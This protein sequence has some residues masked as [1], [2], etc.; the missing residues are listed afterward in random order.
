M[1]SA[2][3]CT[4][5][6]A[7]AE[8]DSLPA[9][10]ARRACQHAFCQLGFTACTCTAGSGVL[11][12]RMQ[13]S[14]WIAAAMQ[15]LACMAALAV[16]DMG[17]TWLHEGMCVPI[18]QFQEVL[19]LGPPVSHHA[20]SEAALGLQTPLCFDICSC[21]RSRTPS[22]PPA[23]RAR[24]HLYMFTSHRPSNGG[25]IEQ[26]TFRA[27]PASANAA[28][29]LGGA[30]CAARFVTVFACYPMAANAARSS[31]R[32][33]PGGLVFSASLFC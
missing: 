24:A 13:H 17:P 3:A 32:S 21:Q 4:Q 14:A 19:P 15:A 7:H 8:S 6:C 20:V 12:V 18:M 25:S 5:A 16:Q 9:I 27:A 30:C 10:Q 23:F 31:A 29:A 11:G 33:R 28:D 26:R 22:L 2:A 1:R